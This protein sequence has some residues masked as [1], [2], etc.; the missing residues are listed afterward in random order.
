MPK[1]S[2]GLVIS[3]IK[4][5]NLEDKI[6]LPGFIKDEELQDHYNLADVFIMPSKKEGFG[7]VLIEAA[8][9]GL[10]VIAGN[11]DGSAEALQN[12]L[13]GKLVSPDSVEEI[14]NAILETFS[15]IRESMQEKTFELYNFTTYQKRFLEIIYG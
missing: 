2:K 14:K 1:P 5:F 4:K 9:S 15:Q 11:G 3:L 6:I 7:L 10:P 8:A 13:L 12:G